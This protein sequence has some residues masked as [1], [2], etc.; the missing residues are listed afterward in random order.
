MMR[1]ISRP[2]DL[3]KPAYD[4]VIIGSGYGGAVA[5][6]RLAQAGYTVCVL[7]RGREV[8]PGEFPHT[9]TETVKE[10]QLHGPKRVARN[11]EALLDFHFG[12]DI[13]VMVGNGLGGGSLLNAGAALRPD[14]QLFEDPAW[15]ARLG[16]P[17]VWEQ[18]FERAEAV[19][20]PAVCPTA[21]KLPKYAALQKNAAAFGVETETMPLALSFQTQENSCGV[22]MEGCTL[23]GDCWIGCNRNAKNSLDKNY[24]VLA[25][26]A[27]AELFTHAR[28]RY[29]SKMTEEAGGKREKCEKRDRYHW[30]VHFERA[31]ALP[32]KSIQPFAVKARKVIVAA[33]SLGSSEIL[34]RSR[35]KGLA[36]SSQLGCRFSGN[37]DYL[38][39]GYGS[40][41][42]VNA[43]GTGS[44]SAQDKALKK[45]GKKKIPPV[46]PSAI[47]MFAV[48]DE[49]TG[50]KFLIQDGVM[51]SVARSSVVPMNLQYGHFRHALVNL[52]RGPYRGYAN[53]NQTYYV[54]SQDDAGGQ[55]V[56]EN[57]RVQVKWP[58][59]TGQPAYGRVHD[60]LKKVATSLEG[61][62]YV[63]NPLSDNLLGQKPITVHPMGGCPMGESVDAGVVNYACAVFDPEG[64]ED[65][66]HPGLYVCDGSVM[67][68]SLGI[69]PLLTITA[70]AEVAMDFLLEEDGQK[71]GR[72][73]KQDQSILEQA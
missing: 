26:R 43:V 9:L 39:N 52:L 21:E 16:D 42:Y 20:T 61:G 29:V 50:H 17:A 57:D 68:L 71:D 15:P 48:Q 55:V 27:G 6:C 46:G 5:A 65:D 19:L 62:M 11:N 10:T 30:T 53:T 60:V 37:G 23:C 59:I 56:L 1:K 8:L 34:L 13:N 12:P 51:L 44:G 38:G 70:L 7:E 31:S 66:V 58:D 54:V 2:V 24:L 41:E 49:E 25:Q 28:V 35:E 67:P 72:F 45:K 32:G 4:V 47:G 22:Q 14:P 73:P 69:N 64:R 33:G 63:P 40:K 36:L 3:V 18:G